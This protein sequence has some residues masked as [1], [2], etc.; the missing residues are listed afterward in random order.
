MKMIAALK[1]MLVVVLVVLT[2]CER[3]PLDYNYSPNCRVKVNIDWSK[4]GLSTHGATAI[5]YPQDGSKAIIAI[6]SEPA[7]EMVKIPK[8]VYDVV[9]FNQT[10]DEFSNIGF[11]GVESYQTFEIFVKEAVKKG[12]NKAASDEIV[13]AH[14]DNFAVAKIENFEITKQMV[15]E[16]RT[17]Q[18]DFSINFVPKA[19]VSTMK[20]SLFVNNVHLIKAAKGTITGMADSYS[21]AK[22]CN[23]A[24]TSTHPFSLTTITLD[25]SGDLNG[26]ISGEITT[27]G[28]SV[29]STKAGEVS[30]NT[31]NVSFL[32]VDN[33]TIIEKRY[34]IENRIN[35]DEENASIKVELGT[36][37]APGEEET[38]E[39]KPIDI[40]HV[41]PEEGEGGGMDAEVGDWDKVEIIIPV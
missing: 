34:Q 15:D 5:F 16:S 19:V 22:G 4:S 20:I 33:K 31:L 10:M 27:L 1:Q 18:Q 29:Q 38:E 25:G 6:M 11:R 36:G 30:L 8:G 26:F 24:S 23:N 37:P 21:I 41:K 40:P 7:G 35:T 28:L 12:T 17:K 9:V 3:Q 32:L 13:I 2:G 39:D 14:P